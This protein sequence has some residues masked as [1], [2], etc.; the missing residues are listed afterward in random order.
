MFLGGKGKD[1]ALLFQQ[2]VQLLRI[3]AKGIGQRCQLSSGPPHAAAAEQKGVFLNCTP[4]RR[5][6]LAGYG[7]H[8]VSLAAAVAV[9]LVHVHTVGLEVQDALFHPICGL[10]VGEAEGGERFSGVDIDVLALVYA[11]DKD[12]GAHVQLLQDG[13]GDLQIA[14]IAVVHGNQRRFAGERHAVFDKIQQVRQGDGS[15]ARVLQSRHL[16]PEFFAGYD[17]SGSRAVIEMVVH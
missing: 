2:A 9:Q 6:G 16:F 12:G 7:E 10:F 14:G 17:G 3:I 4:V 15:I 13:G 5:G 11:D 1:H 8:S